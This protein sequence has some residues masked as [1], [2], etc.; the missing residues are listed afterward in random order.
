[1]EEE[2]IVDCTIFHNLKKIIL[3]ATLSI[4]KKKKFVF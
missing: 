1:M 2:K 4:F 3:F